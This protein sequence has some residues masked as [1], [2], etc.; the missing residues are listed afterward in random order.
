[1]ISLLCIVLM[2]GVVVFPVVA[3]AEDFVFKGKPPAFADFGYLVREAGWEFEAGDDRIIF[4]CWENPTEQND[5]PRRWVKDQIEK[6]WQRHTALEF[7][8]WEQC[9]TRNAGVRILWSDE[10][11]RVKDDAFG[12]HLDGVEGGMIL[13]AD[14]NKW[15]QPCKAKRE[16]CIRSIA[17]HEF[18]HALGF[19]HEQNRPDTPGEC[20]R[21]HGQG[22]T[23]EKTLTPYDPSSIMNYC[24]SRYNNNGQ[25]S[26]LDIKAAQA[27]YGKRK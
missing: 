3:A 14:F 6:T 12:R 8:G 27:L 26:K 17:A 4:V 10:G 1:M 5:A 7:R 11:P 24:N 18:G 9:D 19:A 16:A 13:N 23:K 21:K 25:L 2:V 15:G 20:A 22:Q